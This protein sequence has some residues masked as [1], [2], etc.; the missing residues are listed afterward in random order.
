LSTLPPRFRLIN[1]LGRSL[2]ATGLNILPLNEE[3]LC[4]AAVRQTGLSDFGH[5]YFRE[6]LRKLCESAEQDAN[7]NIVG[8]F[9][10]KEAIEQQLA[11]RLKLVEIEKQA[12]ELF[13]RPLQP[14]LIVLGF[15]RSGTTLL[16]RL[17]ALD[18]AGRAI[19]LW[20]LSSPLPEGREAHLLTDSADRAKRLNKMEKQVKIRLSLNED[21]DKKHFIRADTPEECM[22]M[23]GQTFHTMLYWVTAPVYGY[24]EWYGR[25]PRDNK[26]RDYRKL[27]HILQAVDPTR[28]LTL[29]APAHTGGL[30]EI[31]EM[32]PEALVIQTHRDPVACANSLNSL[33]ATTQ[34]VVTETLDIQRMAAANLDFLE[35]ELALNKVGREKYPGRVLDIQYDQLVADP[36]ATVRAI[37]DHFKLPYTAAFEAGIAR[38]LAQNPKG[39]HGRHNYNSADFGLID[40]AIRE[41]FAPYLY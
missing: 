41:R 23:L 7:L 21:I 29:K 22:F 31:F 30:A 8:R 34:G 18:P 14:P 25:Q 10:L 27:L 36:I 32:V 33:L 19:P 15:P 20:E 28:R 26:Y 24:L 39:K 11:N 13:Q 6:G 35:V 3:R 40:E 5:D 16:H 9:G 2:R 1:S 37:Y 12:P 17:L 4:K 38:Y